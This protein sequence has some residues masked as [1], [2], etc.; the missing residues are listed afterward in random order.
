MYLPSAKIWECGWQGK[1]MAEMRCGIEHDADGVRR[2]K[3]RSSGL[4]VQEGLAFL[5]DAEE[6]GRL[7]I[8]LATRNRSNSKG[9]YTEQQKQRTVCLSRSSDSPK[10]YS[11][12]RHVMRRTCAAPQFP[13]HHP[14]QNPPL[15]SESK[16]CPAR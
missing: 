12:L 10:L 4:S 13:V 6:V 15:L 11:Q 5:Q 14:R 9:T 3:A 1:A 16:L 8:R 2:A 7:C